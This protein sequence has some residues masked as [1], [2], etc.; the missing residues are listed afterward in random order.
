MLHSVKNWYRF[1]Y[2]APAQIIQA[3]PG[4]EQQHKDL[5]SSEIGSFMQYIETEFL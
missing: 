2:N 4:I 1:A 3:I 5:I